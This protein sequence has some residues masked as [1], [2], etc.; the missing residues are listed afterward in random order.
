MKRARESARGMTLVEVIVAFTVVV[1]AILAVVS[2]NLLAMQQ[3]DESHRRSVA[4]LAAISARE[5]LETAQ[6]RKLGSTD[7]TYFMYG[8]PATATSS[9]PIAWNANGSAY[10]MPDG[11]SVSNASAT[12]VA[13]S[14]APS[15]AQASSA[16]GATVDGV[17]G[18]V[19]V[20]FPVPPLNPP[21]GRL[22]PGRITF[23]LS[24][25]GQPATI[26]TG[27]FPFPPTPGLTFLDCDGDG[28]KSTADLRTKDA[29]TANP[30]RLIPV[31]ISVDWQ[32]GGSSNI[33]SHSTAFLLCYRGY[34]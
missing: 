2:V 10:V 9:Y 4:R 3:V 31:K 27:A 26:P 25:S 11:T 6:F 20:E 21:A 30:F 34:D 32:E 14:G 29:T 13:G 24:E 28:A 22:Y 16:Y 5:A 33:E 19:C 17:S 7:T 1:I 23:Y 12:T 15:P 18:C 8:K